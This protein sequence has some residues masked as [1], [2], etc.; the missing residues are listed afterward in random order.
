VI[1]GIFAD[2]DADA[3]LILRYRDRLETID[4]QIRRCRTVLARD[5]ANAHV[6]RY[7]MTAYQDKK[8]TLTRLLQQDEG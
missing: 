2:T 7:L 8:E 5:G 1:A 6:R 4:S 3:E